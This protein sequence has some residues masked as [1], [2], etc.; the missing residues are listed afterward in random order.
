MKEEDI[1]GQD[2]GN[3]KDKGDEIG[4][5]SSGLPYPTFFNGTG[6]FLSYLRTFNRIATAHNWTPARCTQIL[7]LYLQGS[8]LAIYESMPGDQKSR[9]KTLVEG[10]SG[11]LKKI[12]NK[13][14]ARKKLVERRQEMGEELE[15]FARDLMNLV[16]AAY[17]ENAFGMELDSIKLNDE[18]RTGLKEENDKMVKRFKEEICM[19]RF[20]AG[21]LPELR[22]KIIFMKTPSS[23]AEAIAQAKR[24][25]ELN[26]TIKAETRKRLEK[27]EVKAALAEVNEVWDPYQNDAQY[28]HEEFKESNGFSENW[29]EDD[30]NWDSEQMDPNFDPYYGNDQYYDDEGQWFPHG[31]NEDWGEEYCQDQ[32][33]QNC[34]MDGTDFEKY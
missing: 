1:S 21:L 29:E 18:Q 31:S 20:K 30:K 2:G 19:E 15:E 11:M 6:D 34:P 26:S 24:V 9:W 7:P 10:L 28:Y 22:E 8:A 12:T 27:I 33:Y 23:L 17:P 14:S 4:T 3:T 32:G 16:E 13:E 25:D 5:S